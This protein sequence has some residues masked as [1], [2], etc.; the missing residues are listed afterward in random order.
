MKCM[1]LLT[2]AGPMVVL[3]TCE[4]PT[5]A[6]LLNKLAAKGIEKFIAYEIPIELA[7][8]R[9][10]RHFAAVSHDIH[11]TDQLR[12]LDFNGQRAFGL[13]KFDELGPPTR[14]ESPSSIIELHP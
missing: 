8:Q 14:Y 9:Y 10:G 11:E 4:S 13:F 5:A 1:M 2:G 3:T 12:V 6:P 7:E